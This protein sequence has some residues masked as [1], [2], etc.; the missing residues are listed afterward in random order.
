M[1]LRVGNDVAT[2]NGVMGVIEVLSSRREYTKA[3]PF[4]VFDLQLNLSVLLLHVLRQE[5]ATT[6]GG[7]RTANTF[8]LEIDGYKRTE[9]TFWNGETWSENSVD[10]TCKN[11]KR[12]CEQM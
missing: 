3:S 5:C 9:T 6:G 12:R 4:V 8:T 7:A 10:Q 2:I 11:T 1:P